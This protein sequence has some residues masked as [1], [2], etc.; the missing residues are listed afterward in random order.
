MLW[1][2]GYRSHSRDGPARYA[3]IDT[4]RPLSE[5]VD[6]LTKILEQLTC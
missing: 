6:M 1:Q 5:V 4:G 2:S 3:E